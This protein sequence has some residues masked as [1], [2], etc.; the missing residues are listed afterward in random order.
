MRTIITIVTLTFCIISCKEK[1]KQHAS[2]VSKEGSLFSLHDTLEKA[3]NAL[4]VNF[5]TLYLLSRQV[6]TLADNYTNKD[7]LALSEIYKDCAGILRLH[8]DCEGS[9]ALLCCSDTSLIIECYTNAMKVHDANNDTLSKA[10]TNALFQ[11]ADVYEELEQ[12]TL[13]LPLRQ[14]YLVITEK[15]EGLSSELTADAYMFLGRT[16]ELLE[17][18]QRA[19]EMYHLELK[20]RENINNENVTIARKRIHDFQIKYNIQQNK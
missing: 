5:D 17:D 19:N 14:K 20:V 10:F 7:T 15:A 8:C 4:P 9:N 12:P 18:Y 1:S 2:Q 13:A 3:Y 16:Y 6:M 11:L